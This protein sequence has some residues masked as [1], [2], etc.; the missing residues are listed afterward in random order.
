[1]RVKEVVDD[2]P[3]SFIHITHLKQNKF[4]A[5]RAKDHEDIRQLTRIEELRQKNK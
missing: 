2:I 5:G 1:M 4:M 3:V